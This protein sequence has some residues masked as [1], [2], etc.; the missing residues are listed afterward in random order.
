MHHYFARDKILKS[1]FEFKTCLLMKIRFNNFYHMFRLNS[2]LNWWLKFSFL[3][4]GDLS[5]YS[6]VDDHHTAK[7]GFEIN[8]LTEDSRPHCI[9]DRYH[10]AN[11]TPACKLRGADL[12]RKDGLCTESLFRIWPVVLN[13]HKVRTP[14][15]NLPRKVYI[16]SFIIAKPKVQDLHG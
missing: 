6:R 4:I 9:S 10:A 13:E 8:L 11:Q 14:D 7:H 3:A 2:K 16:I 1:L 15:L 12:Y 5:A